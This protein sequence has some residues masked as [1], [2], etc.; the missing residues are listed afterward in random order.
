MTGGMGP[1]G[2][3]G[4]RS[5]PCRTIAKALRLAGSGDRVVLTKTGEP[6]RE[7]IT[8]Q[9]ARHSGI[10]GQPFTL[11]GNGAVLDGSHPVPKDDWEHVAGDVFRFRPPRSSF[12]VLYLDG[13]PATRRPEALTDAASQLE[14]RQWCLDNGVVH[15]RAN[16]GKMPRDYEVSYTALT[17]GI[18]LYEVRHVVISDL[19]VQGFQ[20]DGINAARWR[21]GCE[22]DRADVPRQRAQ[23][24]F[25]WRRISGPGHSLP[26]R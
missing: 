26:R 16:Q 9:A 21:L 6:Y 8:L 10:V 5:G 3:S 24:H 18:T 7:S 25:D 23:R 14:P 11:V 15:F 2:E 4:E 12:L 19:V 17:V 22:P 20:L 13:K 1:P